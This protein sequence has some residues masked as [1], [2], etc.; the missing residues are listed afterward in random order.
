MIAMRFYSDLFHVMGSSIPSDS[1]TSIDYTPN[2]G[3]NNIVC[4][5]L[6]T[7]KLSKYSILVHLHICTRIFTTILLQ[8]MIGMVFN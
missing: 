6:L 8:T 5:T 3:C 2:V 4:T 1:L 7:L